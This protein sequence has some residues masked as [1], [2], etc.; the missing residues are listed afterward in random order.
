MAATL[1]LLSEGKISALK[2]IAPVLLPSKIFKENT[3]ALV[4]SAALFTPY[5]SCLMYC[6]LRVEAGRQVALQPLGLVRPAGCVA[7]DR[8]EHHAEL[9]RSTEAFG[10]H[11][12]VYLCGCYVLVLSLAG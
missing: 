9:G 12:A 2:G 4:R 1:I 5:F 10:L 3:C 6:R 8:G 7:E 11:K